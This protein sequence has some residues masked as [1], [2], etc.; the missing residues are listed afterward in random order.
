MKRNIF[1]GNYTLEGSTTGAGIGIYYDPTTKNVSL[2]GDNY[3]PIKYSGQFKNGETAEAPL[4]ESWEG[5]FYPDGGMGEG[6]PY[7]GLVY[8]LPDIDV[9]V[10]FYRYLETD[11]AGNNYE[12]ERLQRVFPPAR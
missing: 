4:V 6:T 3:L 7:T 11:P 10:E 5:V 1:V 2:G 12:V 8:W 9:Y